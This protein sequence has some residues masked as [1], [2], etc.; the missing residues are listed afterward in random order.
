MAVNPMLSSGAHGLRQAT[1]AFEKAAHEIARMNHK[2]ADP[3]A[4]TA[5][6]PTGNTASGDDVMSSAQALVE[7]KLYQRQIQA[8]AEVVETADEVLGFLIDVHA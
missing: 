4:P 1:Q 3:S 7:L 8:T 2:G 5:A 6:P